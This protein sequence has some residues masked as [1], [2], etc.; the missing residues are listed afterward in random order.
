MQRPAK[1]DVPAAA[2]EVRCRNIDPWQ[3]TIGRDAKA[4][5]IQRETRSARHVAYKGQRYSQSRI[6]LAAEFK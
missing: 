1:F 6:A 3:F 4:V 2:I 5:P